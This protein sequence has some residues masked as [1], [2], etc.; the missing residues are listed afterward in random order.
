MCDQQ[1]AVTLE[2]R[3]AT[4]T[5]LIARHQ[6]DGAQ[7]RLVL[8]HGLYQSMLIEKPDLPRDEYP[9]ALPFLVKDLVNES[10]ASLVA[11]GFPAPLKE[12]LQVFVTGRDQVMQF[13]RACTDAGGT[14]ALIT[15]EEVVWGQLTSPTLNQLV[16]HRRYQGNLQLTAFQGQEMC[17]QRLLRGFP[18]PLLS[19]S[20]GD[21]MATALQLDSLA[22]ELQRS[23]DFLSAQLRDTPITQL[24]IACDDEDDDA[25]AA[26][27]RQRLSVAVHAVTPVEPTLA[28]NAARIAQ[29]ALTAPL[30]RGINFYSDTL[31]PQIRL[32]T[33]QNVVLSW[34]LGVVVIGSLAGWLGWQ[35]YHQAQLLAAEK[36][37]LQAKQDELDRAKVAL[38]KHIPSQLKVEVA[39]ELEQHLAARQATLAAIEMHDDSLKVGYAGMLQQLSQAASRDISVQR[40]RVSGQQMDLEGMARTPDAVPN[41]LQAFQAHPALVER[42]FEQMT[43][44]RD[45]RNVVTFALHAERQAEEPLGRALS[46]VGNTQ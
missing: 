45:E 46:E 44:G 9:T 5:G 8:G 36:T 1:A 3:V 16:M 23:L 4:L 11:D 2:E 41:W 33:L 6:L 25:L 18:V 17:F 43:L 29:A 28:G 37:R 27:L 15:A 38:A 34:L 35:N 12:R 20:E 10:P 14:V 19:P 22:L 32:M 13:V 21:E 24:L 42:R 40:I 26:A 39:G 7:F 30:D 31:K